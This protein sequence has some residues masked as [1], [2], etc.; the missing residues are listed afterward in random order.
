M[1]LATLVAESAIVAVGAVASDRRTA[2]ALARILNTG[3]LLF[4]GWLIKLDSL[5]PLIASLQYLSLHK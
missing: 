1:T 5:P 4:G 3:M 2:L